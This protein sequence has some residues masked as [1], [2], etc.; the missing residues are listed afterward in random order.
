MLRV[1][2]GHDRPH[3]L[4]A[5]ARPNVGAGQRLRAGLTSFD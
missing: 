5:A 4:F 1:G 3:F 2:H